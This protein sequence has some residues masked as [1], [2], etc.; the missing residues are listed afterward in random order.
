M[1]GELLRI[2][3]H[4]PGRI[5]VR[6]EKFV[7]QGAT[8]EIVNR[9]GVE[10]GVMS[11]TASEVTGSLLIHYDPEQITLDRLLP[12]LLAAGSL[13]GVALDAEEARAGSPGARLRHAFRRMDA[14]ACEA[15]NGRLDIRTCVPAAFL[16]AGLGKFAAGN[17]IMPRWYELAFWS[18][19]TFINLNPREH[20]PA[21]SHAR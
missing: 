19:V 13:D 7:G 16:I 14:R 10:P 21:E 12:M 4:V 15:M 6:A 8:S 11:V 18:F 1:S 2:A 3:S 9:I 20:H 5:R 17:R